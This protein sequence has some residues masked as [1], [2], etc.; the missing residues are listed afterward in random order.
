MLT[1]RNLLARADYS[2]VL[3][4]TATNEA[5]DNFM[6]IYK[7]LYEIS[8]PIK[9]IRGT[10]KYLKREPWITSGILTS[11]IHKAKLLR[12]KLNKPSPEKAS[13]H[14]EYCRIFKSRDS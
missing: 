1:F 8:C 6:L 3:S 10:R 5:Y 9:T 11:S 13:A 4:T 14:R 7:S 2:S 12:K